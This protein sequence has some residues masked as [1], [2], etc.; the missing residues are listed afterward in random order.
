MN[1]KILQP[2]LYTDH[3]EVDWEIIIT[4]RR[5]PMCLGIT[6]PHGETGD[7]KGDL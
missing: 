2:Q 6:K 5:G 1:K 3:T 4:S 7:K